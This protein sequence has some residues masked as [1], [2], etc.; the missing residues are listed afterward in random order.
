MSEGEII[1]GFD[2]ARRLAGL[3]RIAVALVALES[4]LEPSLTGFM[5]C[6]S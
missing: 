3:V 5:S 4:L 2:G 6:D 1:D